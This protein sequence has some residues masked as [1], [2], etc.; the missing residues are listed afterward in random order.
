MEALQSQFDGF[1]LDEFPRY[2]RRGCSLNLE[3]DDLEGRGICA[4]DPQATATPIK[5]VADGVMPTQFISANLSGIP[6][7]ILRVI[8][9]PV[10]N[11]CEAQ[12]NFAMRSFREKIPQKLAN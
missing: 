2:V 10:R 12:N 11:L 5:S 3:K 1:D 7:K 6:P 4:S 9:V 8:R